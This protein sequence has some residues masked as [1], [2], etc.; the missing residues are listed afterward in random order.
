[1]NVKI[2]PYRFG[3]YSNK[4]DEI[5]YKSRLYLLNIKFPS[6]DDENNK[7]TLKLKTKFKGN[8][9][10]LDPTVNS[11]KEIKYN[12]MVSK[13]F[14]IR[15]DLV[16]YYFSKST[17]VLEIY[18]SNKCVYK[19]TPFKVYSRVPNI[20]KKKRKRCD[21]YIDLPKLK[22]KKITKFFIEYQKGFKLLTVKYIPNF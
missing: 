19:S 17:I 2:K 5:Y 10:V 12:G 20:S 15:F 14:K 9:I 21:S 4:F 8:N 7:I 16:S 13:I 22:R 11:Y 18:I 6:E 3:D 1:M